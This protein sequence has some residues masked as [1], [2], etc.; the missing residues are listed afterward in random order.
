MIYHQYAL[1]NT[2]NINK[3]W[4]LYKASWNEDKLNT[5]QHV[6]QLYNFDLI[7]NNGLIKMT[8]FVSFKL[9]LRSIYQNVKLLLIILFLCYHGNNWMTNDNKPLNLTF[10]VISLI[11][12]CLTPTLAVF[13]PYHGMN[14]C[15]FILFYFILQ[16]YQDLVARLEPVIM[17]NIYMVKHLLWIFEVKKW[18]EFT[19]NI[20][21]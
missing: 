17:V 18:Y 3:A 14:K 6:Y 12:C 5:V 8:W 2:I 20:Y 21:L 16:S 4:N 1:I 15:C 13:Q 9:Y 11:D 10:S 7:L 19:L